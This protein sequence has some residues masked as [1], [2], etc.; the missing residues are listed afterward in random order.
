MRGNVVDMAVGLVVGAAFT[1][2]VTGFTK[3]FLTPLIG[4]ATRSVGDYS[5]KT[6]TAGGTQ[7]PIGAFLAALISFVLTAAVLYFLVVTPMKRLQKRFVAGPTNPK[8]IT[9][10]CPACLTA[11]PTVATR[12]SACTSEVDPIDTLDA[13]TGA[14]I[15][16]P[17][18][19]PS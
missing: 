8:N 2:L 11:I 15:P 12:C 4:L 7:F 19:S 10:D 17:T 5:K 13:K 14:L 18:G 16:G 1:A 6:V 3:A 9:R